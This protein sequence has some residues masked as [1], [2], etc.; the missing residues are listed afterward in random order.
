[1]KTKITFEILD[2]D[3]NVVEVA[4]LEQ[5]M[6]VDDK[7]VCELTSGGPVIRPKNPR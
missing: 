1:M 4:T 7:S 5:D 2:A 3:N 6:S